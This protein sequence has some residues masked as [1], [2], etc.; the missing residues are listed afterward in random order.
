MA[1]R[2]ISSRAVIS[3]SAVAPV[4]A[5]RSACPS[6]GIR[7]PESQRAKAQAEAATLLIS[8]STVVPW[9]YVS[10][11]LKPSFTVTTGAQLP[12]APCGESAEP[13]RSLQQ[14]VV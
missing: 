13:D 9:A 11:A 1:G 3:P 5:L 6:T 7:L 10:A 8:P 14:G 12:T 4:V 2:R